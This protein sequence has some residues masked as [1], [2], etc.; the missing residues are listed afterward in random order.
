MPLSLLDKMACSREGGGLG[1][2]DFQ[3]FIMEMVAK[4]GWILSSIRVEIR[5]LWWLELSRLDT[6]IDPQ[7]YLNL[8]LTADKAAVLIWHIWPNRNNQVW[9]DSKLSARQVGLKAVQ[10]WEEW[11]LVQGLIEEHHGTVLQQ[12]NNAMQQQTTNPLA[13][14][15]LP[16]RPGVLKCNTNASF[17]NAARVTKRGWCLRG[18]R[19]RFILAGNNLTQERLSTLEGEAMTLKEAIKEAMSKWFSHEMFE[20]DSKIVVEAISSRQVGPSEFS[21]VISH[22]KSLLL[23]APNFQVKFTMRQA[24]NFTHHLARSPYSIA[25]R[26]IF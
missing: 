16:P 10:S 18:H 13:T 3:M 20:S 25:S 22:I 23:L 17:Y 11:A 8:T 26:H 4:Q 7:Y 12:N 21:I 15:W 24:N 5:N 2:R 1:F 9:N 6:F 19:C 14:Q